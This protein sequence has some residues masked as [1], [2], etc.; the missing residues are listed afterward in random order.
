MWS[1]HPHIDAKVRRDYHLDFYMAC[2]LLICWH[3]ALRSHD[4]HVSC[5]CMRVNKKILLFRFLCCVLLFNN[6]LQFYK[7]TAPTIFLSLLHPCVWFKLLELVATPLFVLY[8]MMPTT[9]LQSVNIWR[10]HISLSLSL[11]VNKWWAFSFR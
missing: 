5:V 11:L 1:K 8:W 3:Y 7:N 6:G 2:C 4:S 10:P 9:Y